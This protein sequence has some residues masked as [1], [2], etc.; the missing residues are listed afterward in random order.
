MAS[1]RKVASLAAVA[2]VIAWFAVTSVAD[3]HRRQRRGRHREHSLE[4]M[5]KAVPAAD[6]PTY[7]EVC[8]ACHF[9]L[10]PGLLPARSWQRLLAG[11]EDHFGASLGLD[12]AQL[13]ELEAYL[14]AHA[15]ERTTS[16]LAQDIVESV[17][18]SIPVRVTDIPEIRSEHRRV[19]PA[20]FER[21]SVAGRANCPACHR[22]AASGVY[23][24]DT[25]TIPSG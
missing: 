5:E 8:G 24:D 13:G 10:Q 11:T 1:R 18:S 7:Q 6:D 3:E 25:V 22:A 20:V 14:T 19:D 4:Q 2:A 17:G 16:E 15:A 9:P 21:P 23:D 12:D